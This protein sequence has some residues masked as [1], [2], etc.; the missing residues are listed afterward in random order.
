M[1]RMLNVYVWFPSVL[2]KQAYEEQK[3]ELW[4]FPHDPNGENCFQCFEIFKNKYIHL[5]APQTLK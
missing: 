3:E 5:R 2:R 4:E 1:K